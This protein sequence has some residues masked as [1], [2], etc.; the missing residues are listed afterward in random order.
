MQMSMDPPVAGC[1]LKRGIQRASL[2]DG[3]SIPYT[4][5]LSVSDLQTAITSGYYTY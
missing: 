5:L 2:V 3:F 4:G 1:W